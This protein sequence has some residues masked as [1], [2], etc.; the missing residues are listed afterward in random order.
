M[1]S[2]VDVSYLADT[3]IPLRYLEALGRVRRAIS[4][5]KKRIGAHEDSIQEY[6]ID[7]CGI[8]LG[9]P[10]V[11]FQGVLRGVPTMV[12]GGLQLMPAEDA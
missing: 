11:N 12:G 1:K 3:V 9:D 6:R 4:I 2:P 8:T 10:L 5:V 7:G